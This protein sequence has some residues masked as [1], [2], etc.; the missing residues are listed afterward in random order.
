MRQKQLLSLALTASVG[1]A[2][3]LSGCS[4][5]PILP[6][7]SEEY[8]REFIKNFGVFDRTHDWNHATRTTVDITTTRPT[9]V[10]IYADVDGTRYLFGTYLKVNGQKTLDVDIPKG[11]TD[12]VVRANGQNYA[13]KAGGTVDFKTLAPSMSRGS[14]TISEGTRTTG[15]IEMTF[16][17]TDDYK[18]FP[19]R[20]IRD[21]LDRVP[22]ET[23]NITKVIPNF[24]FTS[25]KDETITLYPLYWNTSSSHILGVFWLDDDG[26][27]NWINCNDTP[28]Q[29]LD[30]HVSF[31]QMQ[32]LYWTRSGELTYSASSISNDK[33]IKDGIFDSDAFTSYYSGEDREYATM[34]NNNESLSV[35]TTSGAI[36]SKGVTVRFNKDGVRFGFYIKVKDYSNQPLLGGDFTFDE[37]GNLKYTILPS[38]NPSTV[39]P[40]YHH[41]MFSNASRNRE[42]G[43]ITAQYTPF[44]YMYGTDWDWRVCESEEDIPFDDPQ[45]QGWYGPS[46]PNNHDK[47][48][49]L[50]TDAWQLKNINFNSEIYNNPWGD[51]V[52]GITSAS[53]E[54][55]SEPLRYAQAAFLEIPAEESYDGHTRRYFAFEDWKLGTCDLND[56]IF[57]LESTKVKVTDEEKDDDKIIEDD[58]EPDPVAWEWIIACEDLGTNDFDFNDVVFSVSGAVTDAQTDTKT[59]KVKALAAGGT[60]PVYL[61]YKDRQ[62]HPD[63]QDDAEFHAWFEGNHSSSTVINASGVRAAGKTAT[64]EVDSDFTMS[65]CM[66]ATEGESGNMGGFKVK[67]NHADGST[68]ISATNPNIESMIGSAPQMICVPATWRWPREN[69]HIRT[70]YPDFI[71]WCE[72]G[73]DATLDWHNNRNGNGYFL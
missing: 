12:L 46:N 21:F 23:N 5:E 35:N 73:H 69:V 48:Y 66:T 39:I 28:E 67:V 65:C 36:R 55:N 14:R 15:S 37:F 2:V 64:V 70:V 42:Y 31:E 6:S 60:L 56:L 17:K 1:A 54:E 16:G 10:K 43:N 29:R 26:K 25:F 30:R 34:G 40:S 52:I 72:S 49:G 58:P 71:R 63:G 22:E 41:V 61:W 11:V 51:E 44:L 57:V 20:A 33:F 45:L 9:D 3:I 38:T 50:A 53:T 8:S 18:Y 68:V 27:F 32:D 7:K 19:P 24:Y 4:A 62:L 59:V 47:Y 13:V